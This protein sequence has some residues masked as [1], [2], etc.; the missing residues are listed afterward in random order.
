MAWLSFV[1]VAIPEIPPPICPWSIAEKIIGALILLVRVDLLLAWLYPTQGSSVHTNDK[2][3][4]TDSNTDQNFLDP[5]A[6]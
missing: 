3:S 5:S 6:E 1:F 2:I 4:T